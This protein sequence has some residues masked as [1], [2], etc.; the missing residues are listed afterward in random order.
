MRQVEQL[1]FMETMRQWKVS[2]VNKVEEEQLH[3][4]FGAFS[5]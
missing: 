1:G 5:T 3:T 4:L 2:P